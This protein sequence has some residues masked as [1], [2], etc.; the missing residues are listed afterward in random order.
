MEEMV[1]WA[2]M[3]DEFGGGP[4]MGKKTKATKDKVRENDFRN[5]HEDW[6]NHSQTLCYS[7]FQAPKLK[8][9]QIRA[10][11]KKRKG[12]PAKT[13]RRVLVAS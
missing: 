7:C 8:V 13:Q 10:L 5:C 9:P 4:I 12:V 11:E 2:D 3:A 1:N 6:N